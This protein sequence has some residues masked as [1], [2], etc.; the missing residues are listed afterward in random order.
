[1]RVKKVKYYMLRHVG[2]KD[3]DIAECVILVNPDADP[4]EVYELARAYWLAALGD[5]KHAR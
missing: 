2:H 4:W 3:T 5:K 1:M